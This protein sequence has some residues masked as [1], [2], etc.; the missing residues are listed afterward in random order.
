[1]REF[2]NISIHT[3][4]EKPNLKN[5]LSRLASQSD[6]A[7]K[8]SISNVEF[9]QTDRSCSYIVLALIKGTIYMRYL[10]MKAHYYIDLVEGGHTIQGK[11]LD[12]CDTAGSQF[13]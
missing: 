5:I 12:C 10:G 11:V 13:G 7:K 4:C 3:N 2:L 6:P 9:Y 8:L 1:M